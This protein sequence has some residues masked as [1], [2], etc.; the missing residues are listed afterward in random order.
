MVH[1]TLDR[2]MTGKVINFRQWI[3]YVGKDHLHHRLANV[4]GGNKKSVLFIYL[5]SLCL[6]L[7][8]VALRNARV[9]DAILLILQASIMVILITFLE[10]RGR[11]R[12]AALD[13]NTLP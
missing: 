5:L 1:I 7:S 11:L 9:V 3:E 4:L 13:P 12:N 8:A 6:G 10:R 2:I